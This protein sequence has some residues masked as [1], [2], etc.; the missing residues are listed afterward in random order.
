MS[1]IPENHAKTM[2]DVVCD[3]CKKQ[4]QGLS[5]LI[6][7]DRF[8]AGNVGLKEGPLVILGMIQLHDAYLH[9]YENHI[10]GRCLVKASY[11]TTT[12]IFN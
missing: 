11:C 6:Q 2:H 10:W 12:S 3:D 7:L 5:S 8:I 9:S 4:C 1:F